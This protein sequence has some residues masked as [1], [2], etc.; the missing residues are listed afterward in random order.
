M[1]E[2][3]VLLGTVTEMGFVLSERSLKAKCSLT[4]TTLQCQ[5]LSEAA[6][7]SISTQAF[8]SVLVK[9]YVV[10]LYISA[11]VIFLFVAYVTIIRD[12]SL[13]PHNFSVY[14]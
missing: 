6:E 11:A 3:T 9:A 5:M 8:H 2:G 12:L 1:S 7:P 13:L 10:R 4:G 14:D